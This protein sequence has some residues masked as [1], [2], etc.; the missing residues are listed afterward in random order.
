MIILLRSDSVPERR[1]SGACRNQI[2]RDRSHGFEI[3]RFHGVGVLVVVRISEQ[4]GVR[5]HQGRVA[6]VPVAEV[7]GQPHL[8][9][10][11]REGGHG[12]PGKCGVEAGKEL[13]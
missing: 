3:E 12:A 4:C 2:L 6:L 10:H 8:G 5:E 13:R 9:H 11:K 1:K 7:V